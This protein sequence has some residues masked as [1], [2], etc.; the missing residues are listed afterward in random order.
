M[1]L[2]KTRG[3]VQDWTQ[4]LQ[5]GVNAVNLDVTLHYKTTLNIQ[6]FI[7][8]TDTTAHTGTEFLIRQAGLL[9]GANP[10]NEDWHDIMR[11]IE[12]VG[13]MNPEAQVVVADP[14]PVGTTVWLVG[15]TTGYAVADVPLP[16]IALQDPTLVANSEIF[17]LSAISANT[18]ITTLTGSVNTHAKTTSLFGNIAFSS[19]YPFDTTDQTWLRIVANNNFDSNGAKI[20]YRVTYNANLKY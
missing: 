7:D 8:T 1:A 15:S 18:S 19:S 10:I 16:W 11:T 9:S 3:L 20:Y 17:A 14:A 13:T 5:G 4:V 6:G 12:L 2:T